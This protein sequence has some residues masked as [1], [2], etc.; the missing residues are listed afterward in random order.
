MIPNVL[1]VITKMTLEIFALVVCL[2]ANFA[3]HIKFVRLALMVNFWNLLRVF[4]LA[5][6]YQILMVILSLEL[7]SYVTQLVH[8]VL[9]ETLINVQSVI[10]QADII[11]NKLKIVVCRSA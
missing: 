11:Y 10:Q 4:R 6:Q 7:A 1:M 9:E 8:C 2:I 5:L 3:R